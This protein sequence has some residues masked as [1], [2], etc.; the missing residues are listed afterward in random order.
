LLISGISYYVAQSFRSS[1]LQSTVG[2]QLVSAAREWSSS[3]TQSSSSTMQGWWMGT[4]SQV[5][6]CTLK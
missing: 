2:I 6:I 4:D 1:L 5:K 3:R